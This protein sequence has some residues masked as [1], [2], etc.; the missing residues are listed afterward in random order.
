MNLKGSA[1][2][3]NFTFAFTTILFYCFLDIF[4]QCNDNGLHNGY[5]A[6]SRNDSTLKRPIYVNIWINRQSF[7]QN[8]DRKYVYINPMLLLLLC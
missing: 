4:S 7:A 1:T 2:H 3:N 5:S 8:S 6:L